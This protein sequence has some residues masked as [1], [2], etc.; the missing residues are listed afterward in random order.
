MLITVLF[1]GTTHLPV[2]HSSKIKS[3][4]TVE[5]NDFLNF[6]ACLWKDPDPYK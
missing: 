6:F 3:H 4:K 5:I 1:D 2:H